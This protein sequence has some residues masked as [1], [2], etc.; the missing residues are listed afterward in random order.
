MPVVQ[1]FSS[2]KLFRT[3]GREW[4]SHAKC[5]SLS[6]PDDVCGMA[7]VPTAFGPCKDSWRIGWLM[8]RSC[9]LGASRSSWCECPQSQARLQGQARSAKSSGTSRPP[10]W[11]STQCASEPPFLPPPLSQRSQLPDPPTPNPVAR[12]PR[13]RNADDGVV[14]QGEDVVLAGDPGSDHRNG[15]GVGLAPSSD[16]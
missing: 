4:E 1:P 6:T 7:S 8:T 12:R 3:N 2:H 15:G 16:T 10:R 9:T 5:L 13:L 14:G 11:R